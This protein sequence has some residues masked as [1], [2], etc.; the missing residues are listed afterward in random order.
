MY[1]I[2]L[3]SNFVAAMKF[4]HL[5][6]DCGNEVV[7]V[8]KNQ[9]ISLYSS[10]AANICQQSPLNKG[11]FW[12]FSDINQLYLFSDLTHKSI[13]NLLQHYSSSTGMNLY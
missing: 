11:Q 13:T 8:A 10:Y 6:A 5:L 1:S 3:I 7:E 2:L 12:N 9:K 4:T